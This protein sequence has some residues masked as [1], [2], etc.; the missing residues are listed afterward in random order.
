MQSKIHRIMISPKVFEVMEVDPYS[1]CQ[2]PKP[3]HLD[4]VQHG[5]L[6][7]E[8]VFRWEEYVNARSTNRVRL[9]SCMVR[10]II[11][12]WVQRGAILHPSFEEEWEGEIVDA[13]AERVTKGII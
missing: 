8:N 9:M 6:A 3:D 5:I 13:K 2:R 10:T 7:N 4:L 12:G 11:L 1:R